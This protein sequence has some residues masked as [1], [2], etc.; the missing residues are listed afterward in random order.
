[1]VL[2][3][4]YWKMKSSTL[5]FLILIAILLLILGT[6][7]YAFFRIDRES[8]QCINNPLRYLEIQKNVTL[9]CEV[10]V[11]EFLDWE[12]LNLSLNFETP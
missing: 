5:T 2:Q 11:R 12:D 9:R 8:A 4:L 6:I 3:A 7:V 1:M 10:V